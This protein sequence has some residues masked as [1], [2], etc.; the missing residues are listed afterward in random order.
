[1]IDTLTLGTQFALGET[2]CTTIAEW[3]RT[4]HVDK[5]AQTTPIDW[6]YSS[7]GSIQALTV[8]SLFNTVCFLSFMPTKKKTLSH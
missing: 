6:Q 2:M 4:G 1:M 5:I 7:Y 8:L 3:L